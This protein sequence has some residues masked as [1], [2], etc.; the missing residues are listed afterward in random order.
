MK[1]SCGIVTRHSWR[2]VNPPTP[3]SKTPTGRESGMAAILCWGRGGADSHRDVL[4]GR[5]RPVQAL[6]PARNASA[7]PARLLRRAVLDGRGGLDLLPRPGR[8]DGARLGRA[9]TG[10]LRD[11]REGVRADDAASG[12]AGAG[13]ARAP[14]RAA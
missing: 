7:R 1:S 14:R 10:R 8:E 13:A 4:V 3:E 6:V 5:R 9:D 11:A 12:Q 2:T